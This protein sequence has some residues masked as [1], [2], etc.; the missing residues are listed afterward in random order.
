[1]RDRHRGKRHHGNRPRLS[2]IAVASKLSETEKEKQCKYTCLL[3]DILGR[4]FYTLM[5]GIFTI[6]ISLWLV[7]LGSIYVMALS[8]PD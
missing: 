2:S 4:Q 1:M 8:L 7:I 6:T 5:L 3:Y